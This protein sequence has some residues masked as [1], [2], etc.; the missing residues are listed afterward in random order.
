MRGEWSK[1]YIGIDEKMNVKEEMKIG[2]K[3]V[4]TSGS[5][6]GLW[7]KVISEHTAILEDNSSTIY[8]IEL[9]LNEEII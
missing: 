6:K 1:N 5:H 8:Q 3:V 4:I 9:D 2:S 7:G